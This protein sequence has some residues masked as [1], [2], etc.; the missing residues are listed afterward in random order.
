MKNLDAVKGDHGRWATAV[1]AGP[2][3]CSSAFGSAV[4]AV[5]LKDFVMQVGSTGVFASICDGDL[6][7][8]LEKA[9]QTF[10]AAC[11]TFPPVG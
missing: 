5:R 4:E 10:K 6:S 11:D 9:L 1:V 8:A 3:D 7:I 2:T